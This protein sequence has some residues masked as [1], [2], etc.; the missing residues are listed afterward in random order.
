MAASKTFNVAGLGCAYGIIP[1]ERLRQGIRS[2]GL[3]LVPEPNALGYVATEAAYRDGH[4]WL[5]QLRRHLRANRDRVAEAINA[6]PGLCYRPQPATFLAWVESEL[7]AGA[8]MQHCLNAGLFPSDGKD[9]GNDRAFRINF[10]TDRA[11]LDRA[12]TRLTDYWRQN[13]P[14]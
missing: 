6:L 13:T 1:D 7:P 12:L 11:T 9:F 10:G 2:A 8:A 3:G 14:S 5:L 4:E